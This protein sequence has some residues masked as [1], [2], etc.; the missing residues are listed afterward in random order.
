MTD[1]A[2]QEQILKELREMRASL[3]AYATDTNQRLENLESHLIAPRPVLVTSKR[4]SR[5]S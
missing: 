1:Q 2:I 3:N 4:K 5:Q